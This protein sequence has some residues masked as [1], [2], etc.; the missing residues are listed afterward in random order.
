M[1]K[2]TKEKRMDKYKWPLVRERGS[3]SQNSGF[4]AQEVSGHVVRS[5]S[6][7]RRF[8]ESEKVLTATHFAAVN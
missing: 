5:H 8:N 6:I 2:Q 7:K 1:E 4:V 3:E